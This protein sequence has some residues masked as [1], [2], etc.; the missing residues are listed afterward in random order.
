MDCG[1]TC[2]WQCDNCHVAL[3]L[4]RALHTSYGTETYRSSQTSLWPFWYSVKHSRSETL[5][6]D[7][8]AGSGFSACKPGPFRG[9]SCSTSFSKQAPAPVGLPSPSFRIVQVHARAFAS[10]LASL[11]HCRQRVVNRPKCE[12][13]A[14]DLHRGRLPQRGCDMAGWIAEARP[15]AS[16]CCSLLSSA[17]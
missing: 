3:L 4:D 1:V 10:Q 7:L 13:G 8:R 12:F 9:A 16:R 15:P 5:T 11:H 14:S 6:S 17:D 2:K